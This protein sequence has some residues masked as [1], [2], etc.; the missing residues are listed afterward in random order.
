MELSVR[1]RERERER[2]ST[3]R[4]KERDKL[5]KSELHVNVEMSNRTDQV[6]RIAVKYSGFLLSLYTFLYCKYNYLR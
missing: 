6:K 1:E 2:E 3:G 5:H 4:K